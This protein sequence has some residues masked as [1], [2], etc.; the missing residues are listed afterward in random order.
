MNNFDQSKVPSKSISTSSSDI[1]FRHI[2]LCLVLRIMLLN[3]R[4]CRDSIIK[5]DCKKMNNSEIDK[6]LSDAIDEVISIYLES[7]DVE[8]I[9]L[10]RGLTRH[11]ISLNYQY[12]TNY[13]SATAMIA[14]C[15]NDVMCD[16][17]EQKIFNDEFK[18]NLKKGK[19]TSSLEDILKKK[20]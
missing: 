5:F 6:K 2:N 3:D 1:I 7:T 4:V 10:F 15:L 20:H 13:R 16:L 14:Q 9:D 8:V 17:Q 12:A 18:D 19:V 11:V